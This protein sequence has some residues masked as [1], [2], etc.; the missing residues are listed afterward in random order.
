MRPGAEPEFAGR[1]DART[2]GVPII[3]SIQYDMV[4]PE[5]E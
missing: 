1:D 2:H 3:E 5:I 4:C